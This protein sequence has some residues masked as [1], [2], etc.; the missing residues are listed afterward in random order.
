MNDKKPDAVVGKLMY[1]DNEMLEVTKIEISRV[2][3]HLV[4]R[5]GTAHAARRINFHLDDGSVLTTEA[6]L[7]EIFQ[8]AHSAKVEHRHS[9]KIE[10]LF[11]DMDSGNMTYRGLKNQTINF[12]VLLKKQAYLNIHKIRFSPYDIS[13]FIKIGMDCQAL[14]FE[15]GFFLIYKPFGLK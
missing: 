5:D 12:N 3:F 1:P 6:A 4:N 13:D 14:R 8:Y 9:K 2:S 10:N 11:L 7:S 15:G